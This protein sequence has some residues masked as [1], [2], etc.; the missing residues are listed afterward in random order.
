MSRASLHPSLELPGKSGG[1]LRVKLD[2]FDPGLERELNLSA[3]EVHLNTRET[4]DRARYR[5]TSRIASLALMIA[6]SLAAPAGAEAAEP[7]REAPSPAVAPA[8][9]TADQARGWEDPPGIEPEDVGLFLPRAVLFIPSM[10]LKA[11]FWPLQKGLRFMERHALVDRVQDILY[12]DDRS[13]GVVPVLSFLSKLGPSAGIKLFDNNLGGYGE[14]GS[15]SAAFG[16]RYAQAYQL[17]FDADRVLGSRFWVKSLTRFEI[18]PRQLF[19]GL[20]DAP[21]QPT[22]THLGPR[23]ASVE[24][25]YRQTRM[26]ALAGAGYTIGR[27]GGLTKIGMTGILN[28][29]QFAGARASD[30]GEGDHSLTDVYD[31]SKLPGFDEGS[32]TVELNGNV[33]VDTRDNEGATSSGAYLELFGGGLVPQHQYRFA[34]YGA[35]LTGYID[36]YRHTRVLVLRFAHEAVA[37]KD[38]EIPFAEL[39]RLGG[40]KRLRGFSLD[41]FRDKTTAVATAEYHY[42]IHEYVSGSLFLDA[43]RAA[44]T[45][46]SLVELDKWHLGGGGGI[47]VRSKNSVLFT[48]DVAYGDGVNVYFTTD[49][50]RAFAGRSEQL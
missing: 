42:P 29:R 17:T 38:E 41:R 46:K 36:L 19:Y 2:G 37:G 9:V 33:I 32:R 15:F 20:G 1:T 45:Y 12:N 6:A 40:P 26:L 35:E 21:E 16:G 3:R 11:I 24:T 43:G 48:L 7:P 13:A 50:L 22:G 25:R 18:Q 30:L 31:T 44:P 23:E 14:H 4:H 27:P 49:P 34:H 5:V 39:P 47:I 28:N 8:T 10:T